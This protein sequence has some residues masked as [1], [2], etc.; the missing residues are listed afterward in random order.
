[1]I[2]SSSAPLSPLH[3]FAQSPVPSP[4]V[5]ND[6]GSSVA[7]QMAKLDMREPIS[8]PLQPCMLNNDF[9]FGVNRVYEKIDIGHPCNE[10]G[11][12]TSYKILYY[13]TI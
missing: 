6:Y 4:Q 2:G 5:N 7:S 12:P 3:D 9:R 11:I 10:A 13:L 1:M 8:P